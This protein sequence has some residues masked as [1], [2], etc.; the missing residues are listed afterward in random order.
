MFSSVASP[1]QT[2]YPFHFLLLLFLELLHRLLLIQTGSHTF[3]FDLHSLHSV[4]YMWYRLFSHYSSDISMTF[5]WSI[6]EP[7]HPSSRTILKIEI[8]Y[9]DFFELSL[10]LNM[11]HLRW[12]NQLFSTK[13]SPLM[14]HLNEIEYL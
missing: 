11:V 2:C 9:L 8:L 5:L 10:C 14:T 3:W 4:N 13:F 1:Q 12:S 6:V 7:L